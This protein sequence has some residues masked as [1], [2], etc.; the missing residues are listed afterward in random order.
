MRM[1]CRLVGDERKPEIAAGVSGRIK[2]EIY[3]LAGNCMRCSIGIGPN[4]MLAKVA[5]DMQKPNG[6]TVLVDSEM[7][8]KL[9]KLK[10][11][12]FPGVGPRMERRLKLHGIFTVEQ[13]CSIA[14]QDTRDG[15]G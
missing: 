5:S 1:S 10:L 15:V 7:P 4:V 12:D 11:T 6:L 3:A 14:R 13:L 2:Q 9:Y 8:Q